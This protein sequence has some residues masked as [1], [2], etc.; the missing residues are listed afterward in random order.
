MD[1]NLALELVRVT[2]AASL[3]ASRQMGRGDAELADTSATEAMFNAFS[4]VS[5]RGEIIIGETRNGSDLL[6]KGARVGN[7]SGP[8]VDIVP[9]PLDGKTTC[10]NG[11][12]NALSAIAMGEKGAIL[13]APRI[14]MEKIAVGADAKGVVDITQP[15]EINIKRIARAL[16]KYIED[17]TVCVLDRQR[18]ENLIKSIRKTGARIKLIND[19][20]ISGAIAAAMPEKSI[21]ILIGVGGAMEGVIAAAAIKCLGGDMQA[22]FVYRDDEDR[23]KV[24]EMGEDDLER[25]Y[26]INDLVRGNI[27]FAATGITSGELLP[28]VVFFSGGA[29]TSSIVM[30]AKT[31]TLRYIN[32]VHHFDYKPMY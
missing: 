21:D 23:D 31:R 13:R 29:K 30:R 1:R 6:V 3:Y 10:A 14:Y 15:P 4:S 18:H 19:G 32:T 5:I 20:D 8:E 26:D 17:I 22:R 11:G 12:D 27:V 25:L 9:D 16:D 2:E 7:N 24:R 28:G